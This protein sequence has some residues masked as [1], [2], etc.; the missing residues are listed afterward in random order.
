MLSSFEM[1]RTINR[2]C[3]LF[4]YLLLFIHLFTVWFVIYR[5]YSFG[6]VR[7]EGFIRHPHGSASKQLDIW[8]WSLRKTIGH[9]LLRIQYTLGFKAIDVSINREEEQKIESWNSTILK[10]QS[11]GTSTGNRFVKKSGVLE[12]KWR[13]SRREGSI[14]LNAANGSCKIKT[15]NLAWDLTILRSKIINKVISVEW[16]E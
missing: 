2:V 9:E 13:V 11:E 3:A 6:H 1:W 5:K 7:L 4:I 8:V 10:G 12:T 16:L 15:N 14:V